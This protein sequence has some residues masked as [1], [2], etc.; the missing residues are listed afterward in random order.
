MGIPLCIAVGDWKMSDDPRKV[1]ILI[2]NP[3]VGKSTILNGLVGE[4]AFKSGVN[5]GGGLTQYLQLKEK[6]GVLY[7]DTPGLADINSR[8]QAAAEI[9][10]AL[11]Q[12][13]EYRLIFVVTLEAGRVRPADLATI[14]IVIDA[15]EIGQYV[16]FGIIVNK[17][18]PRIKAKL[19][20]D[21]E[22]SKA[23]LFASMQVSGLISTNIY[24][25]EKDNDLDDADNCV[26][27][28]TPAMREFLDSLPGVYI[29]K[30][31]VNDLKYDEMAAMHEKFETELAAVRK[32]GQEREDKLREQ[33]VELANRE[34]VIIHVNDG[35][36]CS[37]S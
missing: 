5:F 32:E 11:R 7:G 2:G 3:G 1:L 27:P 19:N 13:G 21:P 28:I 35:G 34:P 8:K 22:N 4:P 14:K 30:E 24:M 33:L 23:T 15:I 26:A 31:S 10:E 6:D 20:E 9:G 17:V 12:D 16:P 18:S 25:N 29:A 37:I 36:G